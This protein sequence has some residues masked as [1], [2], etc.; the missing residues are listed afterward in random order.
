MDPDTAGSGGGREYRVDDL[1][2][3]AGTTVGNV[4]VY[5][6]RGLLP[7]PLRRGRVAVY[8]EAHLARLRLILGLLGRGYAFAQ[9][10]EMLAAWAEGRDLGD[11]LGLEEVIT[12]PWSDE[13]PQRMSLAEVTREFGKY[14]SPATISRA[15]RLGVV[16]REGAHVLVRSPRLLQAG[17]E[18]LSAGVPMP[19]VLEI[20]EQVK[21]HTDELAGLFLELVDRHV[22]P[23]GDWTPS[24][25]EVPEL[26]AQAKRLRPL[27]QS[28]VAASLAASMSRELQDWLA[29]RF[30]PLLQQREDDSAE[31]TS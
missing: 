18:L 24:A 7:P 28:A 27:A 9:I 4:R 17:R 6:D 31:S 16:E 20:A 14:A 3:V 8:T 15:L 23:D 5:Q 22:L 25:E 12:Q 29:A 19:V 26:T 1:A 2:R 30:G 21:R 10:G 13:V 11:L